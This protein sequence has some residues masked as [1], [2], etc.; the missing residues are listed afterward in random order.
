MIQHFFTPICIFFSFCKL[1]YNDSG[2]QGQ[3]GAAAAS[4]E[5]LSSEGSSA[6]GQGGFRHAHQASIRSA[7]S[8]SE[9]DQSN[10]S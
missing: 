6:V 1:A 4:N 2:F 8:D 3:K 9:V 10:V 5:T 7:V